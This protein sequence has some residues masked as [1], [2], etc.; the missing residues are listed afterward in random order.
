[1]PELPEVETTRRGL[2][3]HCEGRCVTAV[4]LRDT[5]L[6]WP[7]T[8][9]LPEILNGQRILK[10]ERR[11]KYL[12]FRMER[13]T[14]LVHLGM[15]GSLRV[16]LKP[17]PAAKHDHIDIELESGAVLRYNDPRRFGSFQWFVAG[18]EFTPLSRLGP[19]PLSDA[20]GGKR[21]FELSRGRKVAVKPFIMDG[22]TVVGV[23]NI[24]ASEALYLA[25]I[26]PDRAA[27][28]VSLARYQRLSE[29]IKQ[30]LTNAIDQGGTTLRD[31]VGGDGKPGYFAQQLF[32]YGRSGEPCKGCGRVLRD[33]V[34]GQRAS[35]YCIACQR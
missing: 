24:Y 27:Q 23:G 17:Q 15:S 33:K 22:A 30:V 25:G 18:E 12:L 20:F 10:L 34:I 28:R 1:M 6:R 5:R 29:H 32:V 14:L 21:L 4:V 11:A 16:L 8:P 19:E 35:V 31:F 2:R 26:R 7:V 9:L 3:A 13:G